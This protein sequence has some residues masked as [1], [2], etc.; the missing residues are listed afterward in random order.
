MMR[1]LSLTTSFLIV[2]AI[3]TNAIAA[4]FP[5]ELQGKWAWDSPEAKC[6]DVE[7]SGLVI[8]KKTASYGT[9]S[10]CQ[11]L[12]VTGSNGKYRIQE[13]CSSEDGSSKST[14]AYAL[15]GSTLTIGEKQMARK[16]KKCE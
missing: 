1:N 13:R 9:E 11:I 16:F 5:Q 3:T 6:A 2:T 15:Q 8:D 14:E 4:E 10:S 7:V 12:K